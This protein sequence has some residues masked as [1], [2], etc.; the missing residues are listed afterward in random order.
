MD[1]IFDLHEYVVSTSIENVPEIINQY[2]DVCEESIMEK[3]CLTDEQI[4]GLGHVNLDNLISVLALNTSVSFLITCIS[5]LYAL[6]KQYSSNDPLVVLFRDIEI[7][8]ELQPIP[9]SCLMNVELQENIQKRI[10]D[11][12]SEFLP[13]LFDN[14]TRQ[15]WRP[16]ENN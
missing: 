7:D 5:K 9:D 8:G 11:I 13:H 15:L 12:V 4:V 6:H 3:C 2:I 14:N 1:D 10:Q 16:G